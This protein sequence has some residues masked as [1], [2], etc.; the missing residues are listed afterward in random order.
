[1]SFYIYQLV[2]L[3]ILQLISYKL[4]AISYK[5]LAYQLSA[6]FTKQ[7]PYVQETFNEMINANCF[8]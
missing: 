8:T 3:L 7:S 5:L 6:I 2:E 1:M 4:S